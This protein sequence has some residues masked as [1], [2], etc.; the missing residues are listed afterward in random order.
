MTARTF[1]LGAAVLAAGLASPPLAF[2]DPLAPDELY[3][4]TIAAEPRGLR[5]DFP[6]QSYVVG[7]FQPGG[8][9]QVLELLGAAVP[10][11][12]LVR[13]SDGDH[14]FRAVLPE[15]AALRVS[16]P[17]GS[18][19]SLR[20]TEVVTPEAQIA[21]PDRF[22]SPRLAALAA[23]LAAEPD[24]AV[25]ATFWAEVARSGTPLAEETEAGLVLSFLYRGAARNVRLTGGPSND[26]DWL[27]R[28][29]TSD[30]WYASYLVPRDLRLS[31]RL[32]PDVPD[33]S[34]SARARRVA[35][36]A[37]AAP[38]PL[39]PQ[40]WPEGPGAAWSVYEGP[41]APPQPGFPA[42][43][44]AVE[45]L[46][47]SSAILGN[48]RRI[49]LY[50][51]P[52]F[53]PDDPQALAIF[54]FDGPQAVRQMQLPGAL[55]ALVRARRL[56]PLVAVFID[57]IDAAHRGAELPGNPD[58]ARFMTEELHP[59]VSRH[60]GGLPGADRTVVAGASFGGIG[61]AHVAL[62]A[63]GT[64]GAAIVLSG[65]F[66]WAPEGW[67]PGPLVWMAERL[68]MAR[69]LPRIVIAAGRYET[70]RA[71]GGPAPDDI[72]ETSRQVFAV[73]ETRGA[74]AFW[75]D[76]AGGHDAYAWRGLMTQ[77]LLQLF[78]RD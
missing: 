61:A 12:E 2:A 57:P 75:I 58:F 20:L 65:S 50:R 62:S 77:G 55:D 23:A 32:A 10:L 31:Y 3:S 59:F 46:R 40:R 54:V 72:R 22:L 49:Q 44:I 68:R 67:T 41:D 8:T 33:L 73:L 26:H 36:V 18:V 24:E 19:Y 71:S 11:R 74:E 16:G 6:P 78:G 47:L 53:D 42:E 39:N 27:T 66:W 45:D 70:A 1:S 37:T 5:L 48:T 43:D 25:T 60:L 69:E 9:E 30:V 13:A 4:A 51:S 56:P 17:E 14:E 76:Y 7:K 63:P 28:L 34:G 21:P 29:G 52:G 15:A 64:F 38:D 35:L